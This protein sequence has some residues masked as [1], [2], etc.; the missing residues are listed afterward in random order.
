M[1]IFSN[2]TEKDLDNLRKLA[3]QQQN[4][5]AL[6]IKNRILKQTHD[7]K[8]AESFSPIT[9]NLDEVKK[10]TQKSLTPINEKLDTINKNIKESNETIP[11]NLL[12]N[13]IKSM[14]NSS[15]SLRLNRDE[16]GNITI[17]DTPLKLIGGDK[18]RVSDNNIYELTPEIHKALSNQTYTGK[19]MKNEYDRITLYNFLTDI[20]Y[21]GLGDIRSSQKNFFTNLIKHYDNIKKEEFGDISG[22]GVKKNIIPSQVVNIYSRL[23]ILLGLNLSGHSDTLTEASNL[24]D[25]LYK[26][27]EIQNKQ[28][29]QNALNKFQT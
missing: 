21:D 20:K 5:R 14:E 28:Q 25:E 23:E 3:D 17:L 19:S 6:K 26:R 15:T 9:R 8:L 7:I 1:S 24:I 18:V 2:V 12:K 29:Y 27:G 4:E 10:S 13:T 16:D 11:S 22:S